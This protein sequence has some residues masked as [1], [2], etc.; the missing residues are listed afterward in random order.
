MERLGVQWNLCMKETAGA[1]ELRLS[2][3]DTRRGME[4]EVH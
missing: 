1:C 4:D 2:D 3:I